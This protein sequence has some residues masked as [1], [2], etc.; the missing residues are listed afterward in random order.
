M[1]CY[2]YLHYP[3]RYRSDP[4][5]NRKTLILVEKSVGNKNIVVKTGGAEA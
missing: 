2:T 4:K 3:S 5:E 1:D